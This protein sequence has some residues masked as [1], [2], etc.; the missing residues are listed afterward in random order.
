M[1]LSLCPIIHYSLI[2]E[3]AY[4]I[5][6]NTWGTEWGINGYVNIAMNKNLCGE[7]LNYVLT[8]LPWLI[9]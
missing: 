1:T 7:H 5:V 9:H 2:G 8:L 3:P 4:W 6:R